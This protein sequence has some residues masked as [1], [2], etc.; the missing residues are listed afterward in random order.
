MNFIA[1]VIIN[2]LCISFFKDMHLSYLLSQHS[3]VNQ[4]N[5]KATPVAQNTLFPHIPHHQLLIATVAKRL[6]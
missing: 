1:L 6:I 4:I 3:N 5:F 2:V